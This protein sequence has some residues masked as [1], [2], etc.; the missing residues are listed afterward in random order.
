ILYL[1]VPALA[2]ERLAGRLPA[3]DL[4]A[5]VGALRL[6]VLLAAALGLVL[7]LVLALW[8]TGALAA[9][10]AR[11]RADVLRLAREP[12]PP[13]SLPQAFREMEPL[14]A[15]AARVAGELAQ[16]AEQ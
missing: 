16:R 7:A 5:L 3:A 1:R 13:A 14:A 11:L 9:A 10:H 4:D 6:N 2:R 8:M 15:A 12:A